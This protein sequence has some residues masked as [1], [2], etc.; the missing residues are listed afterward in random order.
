MQKYILL[1]L[2]LIQL[3]SAQPTLN[4]YFDTPDLYLLNN[5]K[6]LRY[7]AKQ[8]TSKKKTKYIEYIIYDSKTQKQ[9]KF[10]VKHYDS[11][12]Y[13]QDKHP[14]LSL[15]KRD[16]RASF[17]A[18]LKK[19][20]IKYPAKLKYIFDVTSSIDI[21]NSKAY[22]T[23]FAQ[24]IENDPLFIYKLKYPYILNLLYSLII[25]VIILLIFYIIN[26]IKFK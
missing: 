24:K 3:L 4:I 22:K 25:G 7:E 15:I 9:V 23:I 1:L 12:K 26:K 10:D 18:I 2:S 20:G 16:Q 14:I 5:D 17:D 13:I 6:V 8:D 11:V 19:E 21:N